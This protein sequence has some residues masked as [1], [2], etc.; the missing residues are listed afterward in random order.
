[1][2]RFNLHLVSD[3]TGETVSSVARA[4]VAQFDDVEPDEFNWTLVRTPSQ[5]EKV[6]E[7]IAQHPGAVMYTLADNRLR[8]MLKMECARRSLPCIAVLTPTV[9]ELSAW[10]GQE[11]HA[12]PGRQHVLDEEYFLR[13]DAI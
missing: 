12:L 8:D 7:S 10:L 4:A 13:V 1:M 5:M 9:L 3:S 11:I 2:K 6:V